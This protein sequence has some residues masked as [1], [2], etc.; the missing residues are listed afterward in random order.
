MSAPDLTEKVIGFRT[1]RL[2]EGVLRPANDGLPP[3]TLGVNS[4]SCLTEVFGGVERGHEVPDRECECGLYAYHSPEAAVSR[5]FDDE[6]I[7]GA[8]TAWGSVMV[9]RDGF[10]AEHAQPVAFA[11]ADEYQLGQHRRAG[12]FA[13]AHGMRYMP[14][15]ELAEFAAGFGSVVPER[16]RPE[17]EENLNVTF[18]A[19]FTTKPSWQ[20]NAMASN[21]FTISNVGYVTVGT[22]PNPLL[23]KENELLEL[24]G[25]EFDSDALRARLIAG[26]NAETIMRLGL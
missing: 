8:V 9:H 25:Y 22:V 4:A 24:T 23:P 15:E 18:K 16:I 20:V 1:W 19:Q 6:S 10:R 11:Y 12:E 7:L 26:V 17:P 5:Y 3:W 14:L 21:L 13:R 2:E